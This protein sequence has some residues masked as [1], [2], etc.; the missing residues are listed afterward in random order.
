MQKIQQPFTN[1]QLELLKA[2]AHD[3][4]EKELL[5]L[6]ELLAAF[7]AQKAVDAANRAWDEKGWDNKKVHQL[8]NTKFRKRN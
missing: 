5:K 2:F 7:F 1:V 4:S 8:L 3:L 6:R